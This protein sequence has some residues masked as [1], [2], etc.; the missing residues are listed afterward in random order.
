MNVK[1]FFAET[2]REALRLVKESL[3]PDAIVLSNRQVD[4]GVEILA[5]PPEDLASLAPTPPAPAAKPVAAEVQDDFRVSLSASMDKRQFKPGIE[6]QPWKPRRIES[7]TAAPAV[8]GA[9]KRGASVAARYLDDM[10]EDEPVA[11]AAAKATKPEAVREPRRAAVAEAAD[12]APAE[13]A[14]MMAELSA[15]VAEMRGLLESQLAGF[16][17]GDL[18]R[19]APARTQIMSELL[20]AGFSAQL[21][22]EL[23]GQVPPQASLADAR[24]VVREALS[25]SLS[26]VRSDADIIDRGGVYAIVGPTGVGKT[27][28]TAKLAARCVVR[29]GAENLAL[30]TTDSYRIGAHEQLRIYGRILGV[31]VHVVRDATDLRTTLRDLAG[32]HMVLIDTVGMSQRD[33]AVAEQAAMLNAAGE[34]RRLLLLNAT[35]RGDTLDDVVRAYAGKGNGPD[36]AGVV[37]TKVDEAASLAPVIDVAVRHELDVFYVAN[38]QRV[39]EDLHLPN[40][41]YLLHRALKELPEDSP[42]Q[43]FGDEAGL[44]LAARRGSASVRARGEVRHG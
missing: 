42:H 34:V 21:A 24:N 22:R 32:K 35:A 31:T 5:L 14:R 15:Q 4:G 44:L 7:Q 37:F 10:P 29:H 1:R 8:A 6:P 40:R 36:L 27:T 18:S 17:W 23:M 13:N 16:A 30:I 19:N 3:G 9:P 41:A 38:G 26:L 11:T 25:R 43:L 39:P 33:Q 2:A 12:S 28:T 20:E